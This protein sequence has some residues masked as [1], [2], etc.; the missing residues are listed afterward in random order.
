MRDTHST[1]DDSVSPAIRRWFYR[2]ALASVFAI[3]VA[4]TLHLFGSP[5]P[6]HQLFSDDPITS[7][8]HALHLE[9]SSPSAAGS[10]RGR[11]GGTF[12]PNNYAGFPRTPVF[13]SE[14]HLGD[15]WQF[16]TGC[17]FGAGGYK[18]ALAAICAL[19]P[20]S[21]WAAAGLFGMGRLGAAAAAALGVLLAWMRPACE[22][23]ETGD[24]C[25]SLVIA[26]GTL[27]VALLAR[28]HDRCSAS[29]WCG[30]VVATAAAW[31]VQP[32]LALGF[33][34]LSLCAWAIVGRRHSCRWHLAVAAAYVVALGMSY[35]AWGDLARDWWVRVRDGP[36]L[37]EVTWHNLAAIGVWLT[38]LPAAHTVSRMLRWLSGRPYAGLAVGSAL[39]MVAVGFV[40]RRPPVGESLDWGPRPLDVGWPSDAARVED[41]LRAAAPAQ[42]RVLWEDLANRPDL[43]W[44]ALLPGRLGR[45]FIGGFDPDGVLEH[46]ACALRKG[47]LAGRPLAAWTDS[48]LDAYARRYNIGCVV[49]MTP[50]A[51]E[52]FA[53]WPAAEPA[54]G[55]NA[56]GEW[57]LFIVRRPYGFVLKGHVR[58][59]D[60]NARRVTLS[61]VVPEEGEVVLSLHCQDGWHVRPAGVRLEREL[62]PYDPIPF[63]RL[64]LPGP[65][66]RVTISW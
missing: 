35:P 59:F 52:R 31:A 18:F 13:D 17:R 12:D 61:E 45:P 24:F 57:R 20:V 11:K 60:A 51:V 62:D 27:C 46:S 21:M 4:L 55:V 5:S 53:R 22:P 58:Q 10:C 29:S 34:V 14:A 65:V 30:L 1:V 39:F 23:I 37:P 26:L 32:T 16:L 36:A 64:R 54:D 40:V 9:Q 15:G 43:G 41:L 50:P 28:W 8:R 44:T 25:V 33:T 66:G 56:V 7:G 48:E 47:A 2:L 42:A 49:C 38:V 3:H 19:M 6:W 63:V